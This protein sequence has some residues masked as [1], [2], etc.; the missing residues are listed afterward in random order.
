MIPYG[1]IIVGYWTALLLLLAMTTAL[2]LISLAR[3]T[4]I[5]AILTGLFLAASLA[6]AALPF[7]APP[8]LVSLAIGL[9]CIVVSIV[10]GSPVAAWVLRAAT[11]GS[12]RPGTH[13]GILIT[14]EDQQAPSS[15][16]TGPSPTENE[17][18]RG[19]L[20]IGL[21]ERT[22][23]TVALMTGFTSAY[24]LLIAI[25]GVGRFTE[26]AAAEARER[27]IIGTLTSL[28]WATA[29]AGIWILTRG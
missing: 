6:L 23:L 18:M 28:L 24:A 14:H 17:V 22:A 26:L 21:L 11:R 2:A 10:G 5:S 3:K 16:S 15:Q 7:A 19:G 1:L 12:V 13:G 4:A 27:F 8:L 20:A 29:C 9:L 25:K